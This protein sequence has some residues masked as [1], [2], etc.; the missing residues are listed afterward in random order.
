MIHLDMIFTMIDR[1]HCIVF[2][3]SF[4]GPTR[5]PVLHYRTDRSGMRE[6]PNLFAAL[7]EVDLPLEPVFCGGTQRVFQER[8]QWASGCNFVAVRPGLVLGYSRNENT[9]RELE[10]EADYRIVGALDFL[11][12]ETHIEEG[13]RAAIVFEGSELVRGGGGSRCMTMPLQ[14]DEL[15]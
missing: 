15:E 1:E 7:R 4:V 2:P 12:G 3:P 8:E 11:T 9:Y 14:R 13:E 5:H 6:M 10:R